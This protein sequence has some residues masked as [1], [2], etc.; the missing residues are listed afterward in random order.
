[1]KTNHM[2][3]KVCSIFRVGEFCMSFF[4]HL[5]REREISVCIHHFFTN[6]DHRFLTVEAKLTKKLNRWQ[7]LGLF[8]RT[9]LIMKVEVQLF[10][11]KLILTKKCCLSLWRKPTQSIFDCF[12]LEMSYF[13]F[14]FFSSLFFHKFDF[15]WFWFT[16]WLIFLHFLRWFK[17][18]DIS[19][20]F[21]CKID[22][23]FFIWILTFLIHRFSG[24]IT[25]KF[26][27]FSTPCNKLTLRIDL[28]IL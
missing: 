14:W 9:P 8:V 23:L 25:K 17:A 19:L 7:V 15:K 26:Q 3:T 11:A 16:V 22:P 12:V 27:V 18:L 2:R 21:I 5:S 24:G 28:L 20:V 4:L 6:L 10:F 13:H 1:M